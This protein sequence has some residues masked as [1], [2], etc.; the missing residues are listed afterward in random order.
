MQTWDVI[1]IGAGPPGENAAGRVVAGGLSAVVVESELVGGECS[2][3]ACMPSKALLRP[4]SAQRAAARVPGTGVD[5]S[6]G[7]RPVLEASEVLVRRT[8]FTSGWDDS[9]QVEW[10]DGA[11]IDL[12]RGHARLIAERTVEVTS[13]EG[14]RQLQAR[15][16]VVIATGSEAMVPPELAEVSPWTAREATSAEQ[17]PQHLAIVGG[18]VVAMEMA[19]AYR[20]LGAAVTVLVRGEVLSGME[21]FAG[22]LVTEALTARGVD[23][24]TGTT[25]VSASRDGGPSAPVR[26]TCSDGRVVE[27]DEVLVATGR[28][29]R[30]DDLGLSV[31]GRSDGDWV[32]VEETLRVPGTDWLYAIGDVNHRALLTHQGKYQARAAG[33]AIVAR[34]GGAEVADRPWQRHV[35]TAD[36]EAVPQVV[37][38]DPEVASVGLT[39]AAAEEAGYPVRVVDHDLGAVAGAALHADGYQGRARMVVDT[40]REIVLGATLVGPDVAELLH[41]A[42]VAVVG[43]VPIERL[44]HAVPS[45]PTISEIW[46]RLLEGYGR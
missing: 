34:A 30:T 24:R 22:E 40:D 44:W 32:E 43:Q 9:S 28:S 20:D 16:A 33:D 2:Y 46:L 27:A 31:V 17:V 37:F 15:H 39:A 38:T 14:T 6:R 18:G 7:D 21:P 1:V 4:G 23:V 12:V 36:G 10:L 13:S 26:L 41:A 11:G 35:A 8:A 45:Y 25:V 3:W 5:S 19:C 42:T 29:P